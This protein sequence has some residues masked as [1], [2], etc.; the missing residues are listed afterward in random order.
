[1]ADV[2][3]VINNDNLQA[4]APS[5]QFGQNVPYLQTLVV[6]LQHYTYQWFLYIALCQ[7]GGITLFGL[8]YSRTLLEGEFQ[9][10]DEESDVKH[11]FNVLFLGRYL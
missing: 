5:T 2:R 10:L 4:I 7:P 9:L 6:R 8:H 11:V 1:M 3:T